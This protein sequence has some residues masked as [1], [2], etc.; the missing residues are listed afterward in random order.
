MFTTPD[1]PV[2]K[3]CLNNQQVILD[4]LQRILTSKSTVLEIGSG[5][6]QHA[7]FFA[8]HMPHIIW[9]TSDL[10]NN[11][12]GILLW[13]EDAVNHNCLPP[14]AID[15]DDDLAPSSTYDVVYTANT[16]HILS[17][18]R[19]VLFFRK[20]SKYL[21]PGGLL[22]IYGPFNY[23]G[24]FTSDS[25]AQFN[26]F[27]RASNPTQGIRDFEAVVQLAEEQCLD[28]QEDNAMP[29][30]NRLLVFKRR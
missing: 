4:Q 22:V 2:S 30:N 15:V 25:N 18:D 12:P 14:L 29:A 11:H 1:R 21:H 20:V 3:A 17:W 28:L 13:L 10:P 8:N 6:G 26:A 23:E 5:T 7:V 9:Q 27:L 19:V 24:K 16:L